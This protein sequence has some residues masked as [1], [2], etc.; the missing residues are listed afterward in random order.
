M[1]EQEAVMVNGRSRSSRGRLCTCAVAVMFLGACA[2]SRR[3]ERDESA[4][5]IE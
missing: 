3:E 5:R 2:T 1:P 4:E